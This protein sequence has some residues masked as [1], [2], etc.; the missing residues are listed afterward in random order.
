MSI[1]RPIPKQRLVVIP[2]WTAAAFGFLT[3]LHA[4]AEQAPADQQEEKITTFIEE[5]LGCSE[6]PSN[7][8]EFLNARIED[9]DP[10]PAWPEARKP[11][12][13]DAAFLKYWRLRADD[14][15]DETRPDPAGR[16][17]LLVAVMAKRPA[18]AELLDFLP[19][20]EAAA[21]LIATTLDQLPSESEKEQKAL[22]KVRAWVYQHTGFLRET[23]I[24]DAREA[25]WER[26]VFNERPDWALAAIQARE[27]EFAV[28]L[29][30]KLANGSNPGV[31]A[32]TARLLLETATPDLAP[33]WRSQLIATAANK[34]LPES[35]RE[36]AVEALLVAKWPEREAWILDFLTK[37]D[38][39]SDHWFRMFMHHTPKHWIPILSAMVEGQN[40]NAHTA[41]VHLLASLCEDHPDALPPLLPWLVD[42]EWGGEQ[43]YY[44]RQYFFKAFRET[45]LPAA[46]PGLQQALAN[47]PD[48]SFI[49]YAAEA[50]ARAGVKESIPVMKAALIRLSTDYVSDTIVASILSLGGFDDGEILSSLEAYFKAHATEERSILPK[51]E[52]EEEN[53]PLSG[54]WTGEYFAKNLPDRPLLRDAIRKRGK[55]LL[56]EQPQLAQN[57][58]N[59]L[60]ESKLGDKSDLRA[61]MLMEGTLSAEHLAEA[62]HQR[63]ES[64]WNGEPFKKMTTENGM[65]GAFA[66]TL[67]PDQNTMDTILRGDDPIA[68]SALLAAAIRSDARLN[69]ERVVGLLDSE[70]ELL[71]E[72]AEDYL[73]S[74]NDPKA[75]RYW[76]AH[77]K[78]NDD[79]TQTPWYPERGKFGDFQSVVQDVMKEYSLE[80]GPDEIFSLS[81]HANGGTF[82]ERMILSYPDFGIAVSSFDSERAKSARITRKQ[83]DRLH[84]YVKRYGV[85]ELPALEQT[86]YDGVSYSYIH[87]S[88]E[89]IRHLWMNNPPTGRATG[90]PSA[91]I[92]DPNEPY[93]EGIAIY[94]QLVNLFDDLFS[95]ANLSG[96]DGD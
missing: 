19:Q 78:S 60:L 95:E 81:S 1:G 92:L 2:I 65:V 17:R 83:L 23:V 73:L 75:R 74:L 5:L 4:G 93:S 40:R 20:T 24:M 26:Y 77:Q 30:T 76:V 44:S 42:P 13:S 12:T 37:A 71:N 31:A 36:I 86:I 33:K 85:D 43:P 84:N 39:T 47:D 11:P 91:R 7:W 66:A 64:G 32:V 53:N 35:A 49:G 87:A 18:I 51:A 89:E 88:M 57:L 58:R 69:L 94:G 62:L 59:V 79:E 22:R 80:S 38:A 27:P 96:G 45:A 61:T 90:M 46:L 54:N 56:R 68:Q 3:C 9:G 48:D 63:G 25:E 29:F 82:R 6:R 15:F 50:L 16:E 34:E 52:Q 72:A 28:E 21:K 14:I 70:N 8:A 67:V 55:E 10:M 41:A